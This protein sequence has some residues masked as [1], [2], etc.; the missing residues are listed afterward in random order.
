MNK[1]IYCLAII[2]LLSCT[3][4][5]I[6]PRSYPRVE[7][8][9]ATGITSLQVMLN[10]EITFTNVAVVEYGFVWTNSGFP[11]L[12]SGTKITLG[13]RKD[14]GS[15]TSELTLTRRNTIYSIRAFARS[16]KTVVYGNMVE[17]TS[18]K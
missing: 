11:T 7:T 13:S 6:T 9:D 1:F 15:F 16:A 14:A 18:I 12:E 4:E 10:G 3:Q 5:E 17:F 2:C 8:H